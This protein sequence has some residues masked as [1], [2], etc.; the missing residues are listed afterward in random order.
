MNNVTDNQV[1]SDSPEDV[2]D[3]HNDDDDD[4]NVI[5]YINGRASFKTAARTS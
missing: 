2:I 3:Q 5:V 1:M 4:D